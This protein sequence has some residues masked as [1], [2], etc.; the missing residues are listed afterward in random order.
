MSTLEEKSVP[1]TNVLTI[2]RPSA[3]RSA[4]N[5]SIEVL[6][7]IDDVDSTHSVT[8]SHSLRNEKSFDREA[9]PFSPFYSPNP[10]RYSLEKNKSESKQNINV[11]P[12][13]S[14]DTDVEAGLTPQR[15]TNTCGG[16]MSLLQSKS[17]GDIE[18]TVWPGQNALKQKKKAMRR[19]RGKHLMCCGWMS[20]LSRK[21]RIY[22]KILIALIIVGIAIGVGVGISRSV[23]GGVWKNKDNANAPISHD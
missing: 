8:P 19:E 14:Y 6:S 17:R 4:S 21:N 16:K 7:T 11:I 5:Q 13:T 23:G 1:S 18:C 15:T 22:A 12:V 9:S 10:T 3:T 2:N 20:S